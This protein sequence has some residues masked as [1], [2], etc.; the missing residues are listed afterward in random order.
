M[1]PENYSSN[2]IDITTEF[3][4]L[5]FLERPHWFSC[6]LWNFIS[7]VNLVPQHFRFIIPPLSILLH[8]RATGQLRTLTTLTSHVPH[9]GVAISEHIKR[10][11][12]KRFLSSVF[13]FFSS[14]TNIWFF[15]SKTYYCSISIDSSNQQILS[16]FTMPCS[17]D[18]TTTPHTCPCGDK[19]SCGETCNCSGCSK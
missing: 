1:N 14:L 9:S 3:P 17:C 8:P 7:I 4:G 5:Y 11:A 2:S 19:C 13:S 10:A 16:N 6:Y 18:T 15:N 12:V